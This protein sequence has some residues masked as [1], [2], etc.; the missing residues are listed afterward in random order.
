L[1]ISNDKND[2]LNINKN[3]IPAN[4]SYGIKID[5]PSKDSSLKVNARVL[6][7]TASVNTITNAFVSNDILLVDVKLKE[8]NT[9]IKLSIYNMLAKEVLTIYDNV[10]V[11]EENRYQKSISEL[12]NGAFICILVGNNFRD[13]KKIL[14][15]R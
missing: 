3:Y 6:Q 5:K 1:L 4:K 8:G 11:A 12:P 10:Q 9:K 7:D 2:V 15:S 13:A 14:I